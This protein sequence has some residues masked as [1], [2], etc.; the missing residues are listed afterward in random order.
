M[1]ICP[2]CKR[3]MPAP[4]KSPAPDKRLA[5]DIARANAAIAALA[6]AESRHTMRVYCELTPSP[7]SVAALRVA[8][9]SESRRMQRAVTDHRLLWSIYRRTDKTTPYWQAAEP[10]LFRRLPWPS[11]NWLQRSCRASCLAH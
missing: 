5:Q 8:I 7:E 10:H 1:N 3:R 6:T 4:R 11:L 2:C 9:D